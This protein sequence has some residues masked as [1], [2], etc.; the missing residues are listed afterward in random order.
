M[1]RGAKAPLKNT[2]LLGDGWFLIG[3]VGGIYYGGD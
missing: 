3:W 2:P 1:K